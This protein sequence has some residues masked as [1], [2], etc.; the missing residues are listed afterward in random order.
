VVAALAVWCSA[1]AVSQDVLE[2]HCAKN[3]SIKCEQSIGSANV[4]RHKAQR[5]NWQGCTK[6]CTA[7]TKLQ[8]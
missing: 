7:K 5:M 1:S 3:S 4:P 6:I 2:N 8:K